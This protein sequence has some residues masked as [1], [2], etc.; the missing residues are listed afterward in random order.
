MIS[1][2]SSRDA[3]PDVRAGRATRART[4]GVADPERLAVG[5]AGLVELG[6]P[7]AAVPDHPLRGGG[8]RR[9]GEDDGQ[10]EQSLPVGCH[11][12]FPSERRRPWSIELA[13]SLAAA[14]GAWQ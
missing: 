6:P 3:R 7:A 12:L 5:P 9:R 2:F 8:Q 1:Y 13:I 10:E 4:Q 14:A 11:C